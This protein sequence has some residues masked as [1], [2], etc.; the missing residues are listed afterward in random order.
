[1]SSFSTTLLIGTAMFLLGMGFASP[2]ASAEGEEVG[3]AGRRTIELH[4]GW[5]MVGWLGPEIP[6][7]QLFQAL[8]AIEE[9]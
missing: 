4:P 2:T 3:E 5:N 9:V 6:G 1:M 8:P 7:G